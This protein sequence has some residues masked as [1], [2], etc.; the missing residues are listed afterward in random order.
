MT[1]QEA[2]N[3]LKLKFE[4]LLEGEYMWLW[5][6]REHDLDLTPAEDGKAIDLAIKALEREEVCKNIAQFE[7][8]KFRCSEC[9]AELDDITISVGLEVHHVNYCPNCGRRIR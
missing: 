7:N 1:N 3:V 5:N 2:I 6:K 9:G 4:D 8:L